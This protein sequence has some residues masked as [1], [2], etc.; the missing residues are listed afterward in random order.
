MN[1][2]MTSHASGHLRPADARF[3]MW[4]FLLTELMFFGA[5]FVLY[6]VYRYRFSQDF[7]AASAHLD[8]AVGT[9]NT[10]ILLTSSLTV[11]LSVDALRHGRRGFAILLTLCTVLCGAI[12]LGNKYMEW[13]A[14]IGHGIFPGSEAL[15]GMGPGT[16]VFYGL[17]FFMTGLHALHVVVGMTLFC[18]SLFVIVKRGMTVKSHLILENAGLYWHLVDVIWIFLFPFFYL[19]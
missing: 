8:T 4:V 18:I 12:F 17:Y 9:A 11:V 10:I 5:L 1:A 6:S 16:T 15:A 2:E 14:K 3:G 19:I 7:S 13:T